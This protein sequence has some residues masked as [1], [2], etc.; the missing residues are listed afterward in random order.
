MTGIRPAPGGMHLGHFI[1]DVMPAIQ[2]V[3]NN[4]GTY[5]ILADLHTFSEFSDTALNKD[6]S[7]KGVFDLIADVL[8]CGANPAKINFCLQSL[9]SRNL[10]PLYCLIG[11]LVNVPRVKRIPALKVL[12][13]DDLSKVNMTMFNFPLIEVIDIL[14]IRATD[15]YSNTDNKPLIELAKELAVKFN[16]RFGYLFPEPKLVHG[17]VPFLVGTDGTK[18][19]K[20]K[21]NCIFLNDNTETV[22]KKVMR[23]FTDP[24]RIRADIPGTTE[25]NPVFIYQRLFNPNC[26]QVEDLEKLYKSGKIGD[27]EVKENLVSVIEALIA[28]LR[29]KSAEIRSQESNLVEIL[30]EGIAKSEQRVNA[31]IELFMETAGLKW[32]EF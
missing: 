31:T 3:E 6:K 32:T 5:F 14:A 1:G 16:R 10:L 21:G 28:P 13:N 20:S 22:K 18:M 30:H 2:G 7:K 15:V 26:G 25:N 19:S 29:A 24:S 17:K 23:M 9:I 11:G 12:L 4:A 8:A 27:V